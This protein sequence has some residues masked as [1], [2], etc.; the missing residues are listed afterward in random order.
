MTDGEFESPETEALM[1]EIQEKPNSSEPNTHQSMASSESRPG[2]ISVGNN[3]EGNTDLLH[4][5]R[6]LTLTMASQSVSTYDENSQTSDMFELPKIR[7][8]QTHQYESSQLSDLNA[9]TTRPKENE[10][11]RT[12]LLHKR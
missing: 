8:Y 10:F 6:L 12:T 5:E 9:V 1:A 2:N 4:D 11:L 7:K 3:N